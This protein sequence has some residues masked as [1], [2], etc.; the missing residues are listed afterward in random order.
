V[1]WGS[2]PRKESAELHDARTEKNQKSESTKGGREGYR[3][4]E[5]VESSNDKKRSGAVLGIKL[6]SRSV[7][8]RR[9]KV[10]RR[11]GRGREAREE[12][13][14]GRVR[15]RRCRK[16]RFGS[17]VRRQE[18]TEENAELDHRR[19]ESVRHRGRNV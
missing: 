7:D 6:A 17:A 15:R 1:R 18:Q 3:K 4:L 8:E 13:E 12:K 14:R 10:M 16:E 9:M 11:R 5:S 2:P 19:Q